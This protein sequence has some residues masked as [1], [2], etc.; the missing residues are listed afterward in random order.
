M[1]H[2]GSTYLVGAGGGMQGEARS[3]APG[4]RMRWEHMGQ[5]VMEHFVE[6]VMGTHGGANGGNMFWS[7]Y[8]MEQSCPRHWF[9][10]T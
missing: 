4:E 8:S 5:H 6:H 3:G 10:F 1:H 9:P 2:S 7:T